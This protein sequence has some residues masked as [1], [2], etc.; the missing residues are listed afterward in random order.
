MR[1]AAATFALV[2]LVDNKLATQHH[3]N[4]FHAAPSFRQ[5]RR[6]VVS[7]GPLYSSVGGNNI[8]PGGGGGSNGKKG[9]LDDYLD[10]SYDESEALKRAREFVSEQSLPISFGASS[11]LSTNRADGNDTN[12]D[13]EASASSSALVG[14][15]GGASGLMEGSA[16]A[17]ALAKNPYLAVVSQIAPSDL[18]A[19]FSA[20]APPRVQNAV[21]T[22]I[23][24]LIGGLP[25]MAFET[26][27]ISSG[28][29][30]ASLCFSMIMTGYLLKSADYRLSLSQSLGMATSVVPSSNLLLT[31]AEDADDH[32]DDDEDGRT[33]PLKAKVRGK[34]KIRYGAP[35][36]EK[37]STAAAAAGLELEVD[38]ASYLS[39]LRSEVAKLRDELNQKREAKEEALRKDLLLYIRT[40][41]EQQ[42]RSL[43][44]KISPEVL[45]AMKGLVNIVMAGIADSNDAPNQQP[46]QKQVIGADTVTE[47][48]GE[49]MAQLCLWQLVVGY[50]LRE[51]E[52]REEIRNSLN[53]SSSSNSNG[54]S[55]PPDEVGGVDFS[56]PGALE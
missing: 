20:T 33:D 50:N 6:V 11:G 54:Y 4:A 1:R 53:S 13:N 15:G 44:N 31:G 2:A 17:E 26:K 45:E 38:A 21:R 52:V 3:V 41:P 37:E 29:R 23:L 46:Q 40:L 18:I 30:L 5:R 9:N 47:Q 43:T 22:T 19:K 49:A 51:L 7:Q 32:D 25:K 48:S 35:G 55:S 36:S 34:L 39:E 14:P 27:I 10:P 8:P 24:G 42:L 28:Q 16:S 56:Q 12:G